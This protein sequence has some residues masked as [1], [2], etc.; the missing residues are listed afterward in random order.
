MEMATMQDKT[1]W[2]IRMFRKTLKKRLR[3]KALKRH[4]G[5]L[6][7]KAKCLLVTCGDNNGAMN[8]FLR[9]L[10]GNWSWADLEEKSIQEMSELLGEE[11]LHVSEKHLPFPGNLFDCVV[12]IDVH[13]HLED[14]HPFT[15]ELRR[16]CKSDGR[17]IVTVPNG[18]EAKLA[19]RIKNAVGMTKE[20]YGHVR[21]GYDLPELK[22]LLKANNIE[23]YAES[24]FSKFCT[25]ILEL[26]INYLYVN[27][28]SKRS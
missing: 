20:K 23:P 13:E 27:V 5:S 8:Y 22:E 11:V 1:P 24:S 15:R 18:N 25:E 14:P 6:S 9:D 3:L 16:V 2:Q 19:T 21:E 28:L 10:G 26:S 7:P 4:V 17:I 12:A